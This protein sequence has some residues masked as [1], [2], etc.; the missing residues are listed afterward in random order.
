MTTKILVA[1]VVLSVALVVGALI[2]WFG[3]VAEGGW[4]S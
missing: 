4:R 1:G 3:L 2:V